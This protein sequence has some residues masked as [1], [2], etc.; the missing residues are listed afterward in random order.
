ME[1]AIR[2]KVKIGKTVKHREEKDAYFVKWFM[3]EDGAVSRYGLLTNH[4]E[5][6]GLVIIVDTGQAMRVDPE[7]IYFVD[8]PFKLGFQARGT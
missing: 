5:I 8:F 4:L 2:C 6:K 7:D 1:Q 3:Q